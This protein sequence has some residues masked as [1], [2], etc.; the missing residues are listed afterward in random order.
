ML[1]D[2]DKSIVRA[3]K[4][5]KTIAD[6]LIREGMDLII[7]KGGF[8]YDAS[9]ALVNHGKSYFNDRTE[10]RIEDFHSV[11][12]PNFIRRINALYDIVYFFKDKGNKTV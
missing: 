9:K 7:P 3:K 12:F 2:K 10:N 4:S 11:L 1:M 6:L 5:T 8:I